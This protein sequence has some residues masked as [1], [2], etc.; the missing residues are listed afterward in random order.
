MPEARVDNDVF[1]KLTGKDPEWFIART[2]IHTR[3]RA[4]QDE[5]TTSMGCQAVEQLLAANPKALDGV[6]LI[7]GSSYTPDD[8]LS[9]MPA[10]VQRQFNITDTR[11]Y[12]LSTA[13]S[14]FIS[15]LEMT[16]LLLLSGEVEKALIVVSEHNSF[17]SDDADRFSG[18]LWG[19]GA[20][21]IL[22]SMHPQDAMFSVDYV[23]SRGV[24]CAGK[25]PD[26]ISLNPAKGNH[27][28]QMSEGRDVFA[29]ACEYLGDE[30]RAALAKLKM[31]LA[32]IDWLVPHQANLRILTNVAKS[33]GL[34]MER[35]VVT[36][37]KLGNTGCASIPI[38]I[39]HVLSRIKAGDMVAA[40]AF[41]GGYSTG[42]AILTRT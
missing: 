13:C 26:A 38:S 39:H 19:D 31:K 6:D 32:D 21:A 7:I 3:S 30:I 37:V 10:R 14:S 23:S 2:G 5:S 11:V 12:F 20:A 35:C 34:P 27:G 41:G 18:H 25:G 42:A 4:G 22:V 17:Y 16:R 24:A 8:T 28:L 36:V 1:C 40:T 9:T 33:L 29:R 15:A